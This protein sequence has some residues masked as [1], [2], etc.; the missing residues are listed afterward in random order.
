MMNLDPSRTLQESASAGSAGAASPK[1]MKNPQNTSQQCPTAPKK[2]IG[3]TSDSPS[4]MFFHLLCFWLISVFMLPNLPIYKDLFHAG[5]TAPVLPDE[6]L[7]YRANR[8]GT[9]TRESLQ[10]SIDSICDT[11][12]WLTEHGDDEGKGRGAKAR[13][14]LR[15]LVDV[16]NTEK[17]MLIKS[18]EAAPAEG[19]NVSGT[20]GG[21]QHRRGWTTMGVVPMCVVT[22][23]LAVF[24][25]VW[26]GVCT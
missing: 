25:W 9:P 16:I 5:N 18:L 11:L 10:A 3:T 20:G 21:A 4:R 24:G 8:L 22:G 19:Q 1:V 26:T 17:A 12:V 14:E 15:K 23:F 7:E 2:P 13:V 6:F